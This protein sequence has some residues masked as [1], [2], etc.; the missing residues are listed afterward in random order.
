MR[1]LNATRIKI[2]GV[3]QFFD[4]MV[5]LY[6][7]HWKI[8]TATIGWIPYW[9]IIIVRYIWRPKMQEKYGNQILRWALIHWLCYFRGCLNYWLWNS[10]IIK[11]TSFE[12]LKFDVQIYHWRLYNSSWKNTFSFYTTFCTMIYEANLEYELWSAMAIRNVKQKT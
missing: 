10:K 8:F 11:V 1:V 9:K 5:Y 7:R 12:G 4:G 6:V 3:V 2:N